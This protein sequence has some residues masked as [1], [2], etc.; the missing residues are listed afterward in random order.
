[1]LGRQVA[2]RAILF[3]TLQA[4][5][6]QIGIDF[7]IE[8]S[9]RQRLRSADL[10]DR[11][12]QRLGQEGRPAGQQVIQQRS[13]RIDIAPGPD[14]SAVSLLRRHVAGGSG[15]IVLATVRRVLAFDTLGDSKI[16]DVGPARVIQQDV[17]RLDVSVINRL[18]LDMGKMQRTSHGLDDFRRPLGA[19]RLFAHQVRQA[20]TFDVGHRDEVLLVDFSGIV[21]GDNVVVFQLPSVLSFQHELIDLKLRG[22]LPRQDR[23]QRN[24][25]PNGLLPRAIDDAHC[26]TSDLIQEFVLSKIGSAIGFRFPSL[27][28]LLRRHGQ[29]GRQRTRG[30]FQTRQR[31]V[32][33]GRCVNFRRRQR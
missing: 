29:R 19:H 32:D 11:F 18:R 13:C 24:D 8:F 25:S 12:Q 1:M 30:H 22:E 20:V 28:H 31:G 6:F 21:D 4:D 2:L 7:R 27:G 15:D 9:R 23:L 14:V 5:R 16:G 10:S 17:R 26:S 3:E 33:D